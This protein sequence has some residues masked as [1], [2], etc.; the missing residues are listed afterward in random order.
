M[1]ARTRALRTLASFVALATLAGAAAAQAPAGKAAATVNGEPIPLAE[2]EA[3]L[4]ARGPNPT[5]VPAAQTRQMQLDALAMLI[6]D[7][8]LQQYLRKT[9]PAPDRGE[10]A[11]R[12][13]ELAE[14]LKKQGKTLQDF[15]KETNQTPEQVQSGIVN[16]L[17]WAAFVKDK[18][19]DAEVKR[20][21]DENREFFDQVLVRASH[22]VLRVTPEA[23]AGERQTAEQK[24]RALRTE[25][26]AGRLDFAEAAKKNSQCQSAPGGGDVGL[27][28][29]KG[30]IMEPFAKTAFAMKVGEVSDVVQTDYGLHL[31]KVTERQPGQPSDFSKIKEAV[32][33]VC[34]E[35][36]RQNV[37]AQLRK[38]AEIKMHLP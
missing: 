30:Y 18:V 38:Q 9:C 32:R 20:Y 22:I 8:L 36:V 7:V 13:A 4:K 12:F 37:V 2:V 31:I 3:I 6:D 19:G 16:M 26:L 33:E 14:A 11:K 23:S 27:F 34:V 1:S 25:I 29:R 15:C 10:V 5:P 17:Q 21:Y 35:E 28:P 24:L